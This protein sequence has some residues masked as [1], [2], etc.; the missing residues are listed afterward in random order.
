MP[1]LQNAFLAD[2]DPLIDAKIHE[3]LD[4]NVTSLTIDK[5][6]KVQKDGQDWVVY[7]KY[8]LL[9]TDTDLSQ[10]EQ[11]TKIA[12]LMGEIRTM[13]L[14]FLLNEGATDICWHIHFPTFVFEGCES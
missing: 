13:I 6:F 5:K 3:R 10:S 2:L 14:T 4:A 12:N 9:G 1:Q 11:D 7:P 8:V